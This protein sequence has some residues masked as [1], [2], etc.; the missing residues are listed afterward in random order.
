MAAQAAIYDFL[1]TIGCKKSWMLA[2]ASMT[3]G[4]VDGQWQSFLVLRTGGMGRP[5]LAIAAI[6]FS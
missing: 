2:C 4:V 6:N 1:V 5:G 3:G